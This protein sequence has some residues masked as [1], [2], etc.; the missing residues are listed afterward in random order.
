MERLVRT[1]TLD[2]LDD[3][4]RLLLDGKGKGRTLVIP[5]TETVA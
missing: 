4:M 3:A 2:G 1:I 5:K